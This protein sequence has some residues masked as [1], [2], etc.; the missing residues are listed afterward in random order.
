MSSAQKRAREERQEARDEESARAQLMLQYNNMRGLVEELRRR[1]EEKEEMSIQCS[2]LRDQATKAQK[3]AR[4]LGSQVEDSSFDSLTTRF[5][6]DI[7]NSATLEKGKG[8]MSIG[9]IVEYSHSKKIIEHCSA[10]SSG[11]NMSFLNVVK[12][13]FAKAFSTSP[14]NKAL[15]LNSSPPPSSSPSS[16]SSSS[17]SL[18]SD[19]LT[20]QPNRL[21]DKCLAA[22]I[23][24]AAL[25]ANRL[26]QSIT[27][28]TT[29]LNVLSETRSPY[30]ADM[31]DDAMVGGVAASTINRHFHELSKKWV[32]W[33]EIPERKQTLICVFD[34]NSLNY[35]PHSSRSGKAMKKLSRSFI[36][37]M[38]E[39]F[40]FAE[41]QESHNISASSD[42]I[43][44]LESIQFNPELS[45]LKWWIKEGADLNL[46][47]F[48]YQY[49]PNN[50]E[51]LPKNYLQDEEYMIKES[52]GSLCWVSDKSYYTN[53]IDEVLS[54]TEG[55]KSTILD[56]GP[57]PVECLWCELNS[58]KGSR[59]CKWCK[60]KL[61]SIA[62]V[63]EDKLGSAVLS[64]LV[65]TRRPP[66]GRRRAYDE[67]Y[68]MDKNG[69]IFKT[70]VRIDL[71]SMSCAIADD[72]V[73]KDDDLEKGEDMYVTKVIRTLLPSMFIN[74]NTLLAIRK[75]LTSFGERYNLAGFCNT[76]VQASDI[77]Y[78]L[79]CVSDLGA[80]DLGS[81][82][83]P[84]V[85]FRSF[86][87][88][89]GVFHEDM[90]WIELVMDLL[91]SIGGG[92]LAFFHTFES[93]KAQA[94]LRRAG[95]VHKANDFLR[96]VC[97]TSLHAA[98]LKA[99]VEHRQ[100]SDAK[101]TSNNVVYS[102]ARQWAEDVITDDKSVDLKFK[103]FVFFL[104]RILPAYELIKKG[105]RTGNIAAYHAGRRFLLPFAFAL[106]K[107]NYAPAIARDMLQY[108][109]A[110][111]LIRKA[112]N[113][114]FKLY[115]EGLNGKA[116]ESNKKQKRYVISATSSGVQAGAVLVN[117]A[118]ALRA[119][120][121]NFSEKEPSETQPSEQRTPTDL[122]EDTLLCTNYLTQQY[123][124]EMAPL[125]V[126][127]EAQM[128]NGTIIAKELTLLTLF[129]YG[130]MLR[131]KWVEAYFT[132]DSHE[133][134][135]CTRGRS[136]VERKV[137]A[138]QGGGVT[139][140]KAGENGGDD[141]GSVV[142]LPDATPEEDVNKFVNK[143]DVDGM[144]T[145]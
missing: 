83:D 118:E 42:E 87:Y 92:D 15:I 66:R 144:D 31:V 132:S 22:V 9:R 18:S 89:L 129:E 41:I 103:T 27:S 32:K 61:R 140:I 113:I 69:K 109:L 78:F 145:N 24:A 14:Y 65:N 90:M 60:N 134:P 80:T 119:A 105:T 33:K 67:V 17:S 131:D 7:V 59:I 95:D 51:E 57:L 128:F 120:Q 106:G 122:E 70:N 137:I 25:V 135:S 71:K 121:R 53:V 101:F 8:L 84:S 107:V 34:N 138:K 116:E 5:A 36:W 133:L 94:Y 125:N 2:T 110:P 99:F 64:T 4:E 126:S 72:K 44:S 68:D 46:V 58:S 37:T 127:T 26:Y 38:R 112:L 29:C 49:A 6:N 141:D 97:K 139:I 111:P 104:F 108:N 142:E 88:V 1:D 30:A 81:F 93:E 85:N 76:D 91:Y 48:G 28:Y 52:V 79:F 45:P 77:R 74:P 39:L 16:T 100:K 75:I 124:F 117:S 130:K 63:R 86:V 73:D 12:E 98:F 50:R 136:F 56:E 35:K 47:K 55:A 20:Q 11:D 13:S 40:S 62:Q 19:T 114:L 102:E 21:I 23:D 143:D 123:V 10:T 43:E 96:N 3:K 115:D 82:N 54:P